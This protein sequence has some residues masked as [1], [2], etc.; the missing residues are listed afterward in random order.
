MITEAEIMPLLLTACP[1]LVPMW[2]EH[3]TRWKAEER[4][5]YNDAA[6]FAHYLVESY[7]RGETSEFAAALNTIEK[8]LSEGSQNARD[9]V[10]FGVLE[11]VQTIASHSCGADVFV[12]WLGPTSR[13]AWAEI[14]QMWV[15]KESLMDVIRAE[16]RGSK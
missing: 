14:E 1:G 12:P 3:L 16:R 2:Q 5:P 9:M 15:G 6:E 8:I 7:N 13:I 11:D 10:G 4:G